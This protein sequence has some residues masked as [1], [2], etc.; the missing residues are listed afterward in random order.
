MTDCS[1]S[2]H[3]MFYKISMVLL[4][5][6]VLTLLVARVINYYDSDVEISD[7]LLTIIAVFNFAVSIVTVKCL[8][9][10]NSIYFEVMRQQNK[11]SRLEA[12]IG[13]IRSER[14]DFINHLQTI[15]GLI[16]SGAP[17]ATDYIKQLNSSCRINSQIMNVFNPSL[18]ILIQNKLDAARSLGIELRLD[19]R[20][21]ID[22]INIMPND[23]VAIFGN[24]IDNAIDSVESIK[25]EGTKVITF[26]VSETDKNYIFCLNDTGPE[27]GEDVINNMYEVGYSTKG[28]GRGYGLALVRNTVR[29]Y[30][31]RV[32]FDQA[33]KSFTVIIPKREE[34]L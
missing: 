3:N 25:D 33:T 34:I 16:A 1:L 20:S 29:T 26:E 6:T 27:I 19:I 10:T 21:T 5:E 31:G 7:V 14:H 30:K 32:L 11:I 15:Y 23:L 12:N 9:K 2:N 4:M 17:G 28:V 8:L 18:R 24:I 22:N 13:L